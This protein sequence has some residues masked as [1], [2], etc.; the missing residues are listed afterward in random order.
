MNWKT[1]FWS[2]DNR[3][4]INNRKIRKM[5]RNGEEGENKGRG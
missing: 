3:M 1:V 5:R 2:L 4:A